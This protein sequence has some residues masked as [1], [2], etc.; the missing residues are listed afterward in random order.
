[1]SNQK[2][3]TRSDIRKIKTRGGHK[4]NLIKLKGDIKDILE[5]YRDK[6]E[7][8]FLTGKSC[9]QR[10]AAVIIKLNADILERLDVG[11]EIVQEMS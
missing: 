8:K 5:R 1:M 9:L 11:N 3:Q 10:K 2:E 6:R 7:D 4:T